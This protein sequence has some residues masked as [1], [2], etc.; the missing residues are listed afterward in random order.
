MEIIS[1]FIAVVF[2]RPGSICD[3]EFHSGQHD[4]HHD[5]NADDQ[6]NDPS[7]GVWRQLQKCQRQQRDAKRRHQH[8][9]YDILGYRYDQTLQ[10]GGGNQGCWCGGA[11]RHYPHDHNKRYDQLLIGLLAV[12]LSLPVRAQDGGTTAIANPVA[13]STGSVSNQAVQI[14][15]GSYSQ[16]GFG[17]GHTC[18]SSTLV[19]TPF[20]LGND[21]N[22]VEA[23]YLRNQNY[24]A[25]VSLSLPLDFEM[26]RLCKDLAKRKIEKERLD[27]ELVRLKVCGEQFR[28]GVFYHPD[29]LFANICADIV[30]RLPDGRVITGNGKNLL[31]K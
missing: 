4:Q 27:Y 17:V 22:N 5:N 19:F 6:R 30:G 10:P 28:L 13:T 21:V 23:P 11:N 26:V 9:W 8:F 20:Y 7:S 24:G 16:Q 14:N 3:T 1:R 25:Q 29:S 18:N 31:M 12:I 15:Q 2:S